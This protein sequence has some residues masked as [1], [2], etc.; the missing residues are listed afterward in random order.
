MTPHPPP[1]TQDPAG[2]AQRLLRASPDPAP[3]DPIDWD[4]PVLDDVWF[5][6]PERLSLYG[7]PL[8]EEMDQRQRVELSRHEM[9]SFMS[10]GIWTELCLMQL[11]A[12][13]MA[14]SG[15]FGDSRSTYALTEVAD[16]TRHCVMFGRMI[17]AMGCS[18]YTPSA[19]VQRLFTF[20]STLYSELSVFALAL[21]IE[22]V[23][24][25]L[26][27]EIVRDERVQPLVREVCR[28]HVAEE[29]RHVSFAR[30]ELLHTAA[31]ASR[32]HLALQRE[33][34]AVS[35]YVALAQRIH[36][37][38]YSAAGL[39]PARARR[40]ARGNPHY[41]GTLRWSGEKLTAF[42]AQAG[43]IGRPQRHWWRR[44]GLLP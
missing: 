8:W 14:S 36:P 5:C 29:A 35:A 18:P 17:H 32:A 38:V 3:A 4:T 31:R 42:L 10:A 23:N 39:D 12:R 1:R 44:T 15:N 9:A 19:V 6:R 40:E 2:V 28:L 41:R 24:D 11:L 37:D 34:T 16:E 22:E 20:A 21:V 25:R 27:R 7:T 26:Q 43:M 30:T 13:H 33:L